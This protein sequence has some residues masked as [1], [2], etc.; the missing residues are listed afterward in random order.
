MKEE[1]EEEKFVW[2][3]PTKIIDGVYIGSALSAIAKDSDTH[4]FQLK[5]RYKKI[6]PFYLFHS[7]GLEE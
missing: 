4:L 3:F 7:F 1:K 6:F 2:R 5:I